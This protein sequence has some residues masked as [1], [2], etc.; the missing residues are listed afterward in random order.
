M[1]AR[2]AEAAVQGQVGRVAATA[3]VA[4]VVVR[5]AAV[6]VEAQMAA[7][8]KAAALEGA[9]L[10]PYWADRAAVASETRP[11]LSDCFHR[12]RGHSLRTP[13]RALCRCAR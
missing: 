1:D 8:V 10:G 5:A 13:R 6:V 3:A 7:V 4:R 9:V 2:V 11:W 12:S